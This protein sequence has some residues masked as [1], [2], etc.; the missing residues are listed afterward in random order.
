V[1]VSNLRPGFESYHYHRR[2]FA[3][4]FR[5]QWS[6]GSGSNVIVVADLRPK[7]PTPADLLAAAERLQKQKRFT[8][9]L[10]AVIRSG[11]RGGYDRDGPILT[12]DY[13]PTDVL[14]SIPRD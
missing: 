7:A 5:N 6:Y 1:V 3:A 13:A 2:T 14:R 8:V 12:D 10:P 4:V 11:S 9:D